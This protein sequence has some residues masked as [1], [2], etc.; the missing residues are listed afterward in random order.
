MYPLGFRTRIEVKGLGDILEGRARPGHFR[1][2]ATVVGKLF[3][4]AQPTIAY[5]GQKDYQQARIIQQMT[6]D[7]NWPMRIRVMPTVREPDGL[8]MSSRNMYLQPEERR[9][10]AVLFQA[11]ST[12]KTAIRRG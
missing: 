2:V 3:H 7:L 10:A 1:G 6:Q 4:L 5:F 12:G 11:L 9:Q 8:A